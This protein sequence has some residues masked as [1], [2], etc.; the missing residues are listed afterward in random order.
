MKKQFTWSK[1]EVAQMLAEVMD[2]EGESF[3]LIVDEEFTLVVEE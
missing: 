2:V 1:Q 3:D